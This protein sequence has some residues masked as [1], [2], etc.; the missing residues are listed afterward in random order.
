MAKKST[1][2]LYRDVNENVYYNIRIENKE[3]TFKQAIFRS[4]K[5]QNIISNPNEYELAVV[6]F[7][8]PSYNIPVYFFNDDVLSFTFGVEIEGKEYVA[9][10]PFEY[11]LKRIPQLYG[12]KT[13][14][15]YNEMIDIMNTTLEDLFEDLKTAVEDDG[16]DLPDGITTPP[17]FIFDPTTRLISYHIEDGWVDEDAV[18]VVDWYC[19]P[20]VQ[21]L[22]PT[23][24]FL[25]NGGA[26]DDLKYQFSPV[27]RYFNKNTYEGVEYLVMVQ[28]S[29][30]L[31][32][33]SPLKTIQFQ[34]QSIPVNP[35]FLPSVNNAFSR[36]ITDFEAPSDDPSRQPIQ[37]FP[38][39]PLRYYD[40]KSNYGL[41]DID[42]VVEWVDC[43]GT[44]YPVYL[45]KGDI[46]TC[47]LLFRRK[48]RDILN[49]AIGRGELEGNN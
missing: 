10:R 6:R 29:P 26:P 16:K 46:L 2:E 37:F 3:E 41:R 8:V 24:V 22:F 43:D 49:D 5:V 19:S 39:G 1:G 38:Q 33:W 28:D 9:S 25:Y 23:F 44:P 18:P 11:I 31:Y 40:L 15:S 14:W 30:T 35:E 20:E 27:E 45:T 34:T 21:R 17:F 42:L 47:K 48:T 4:T 36:V 13:L 7:S 32:L 12:R